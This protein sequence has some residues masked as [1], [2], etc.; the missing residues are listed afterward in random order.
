MELRVTVA[1]GAAVIVQSGLGLVWAGAASERLA[2]LER[3]ADDN[4]EIIERT[5]RLEEQA[6]FISAALVRIEDKLDAKGEG[7]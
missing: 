1:I 3:R 7:E 2:Q 6:R 5:A 4:R